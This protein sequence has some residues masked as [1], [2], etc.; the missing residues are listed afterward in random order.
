M[1]QLS[2][3]KYPQSQ[4]IADINAGTSF[5]KVVPDNIG[6]LVYFDTSEPK[7]EPLADS[8][9][10]RRKIIAA[11]VTIAAIAGIWVWLYAHIG[12]AIFL[13]L[14]A[15]F[16]GYLFF[17]DQYFGGQDYFIGSE[18][19]AKYH[20]DT[21]RENILEKEGHRFDEGFILMH[22]EVVKYKN[23][24]Y[25]G[26]D[27]SFAYL[28]KPNEENISTTVD[29]I[30]ASYNHKEGGG[31]T[32]NAE[33]DFWYHIEDQITS[34]YLYAAGKL[35]EAGKMV[36][37]FMAVKEEDKK[38]MAGAVI[39]LGPGVIQYGNKTYT[40]D[41]L[42]RVYI[43]RGVVYFED[44]NYSNKMFGLKKTGEKMAIPLEMIGN[45]K[46]FIMLLAKLYGI[47]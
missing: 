28:S 38:W 24:F 15:A 43:N 42:K 32:G 3:S 21:N 29:E 18:G 12:W 37:I 11:V 8:V 31:N 16:I 30:Y 25:D 14:V 20:F 19:Y 22:K 44:A 35:L 17:G 7:A 9:Y 41:D 46:A 1:P 5:V 27:Y 13:T 10:T 34:N 2:E 36:P 23:G 45:R 47:N 26:T 39:H 6:D 33:Y 40:K 4:V